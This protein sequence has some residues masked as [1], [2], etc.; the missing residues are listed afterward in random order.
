VLLTLHEVLD[1]ILLTFVS[2]LCCA[3]AGYVKK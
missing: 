3:V 2:F 1:Q